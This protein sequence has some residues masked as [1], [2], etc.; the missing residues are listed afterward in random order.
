MFQLN[1]P[2][3]SYILINPEKKDNT[4][5]EN[6]WNCERLCSVLYSKD[7]TVVPIKE[8][9]KNKYS[10][11]FFGIFPLTNNDELRQETL[12]IL[13]FL[14][15]NE[16]IIKYN[17]S[18]SPIKITKFGEEIPLTFSVYENDENSR[19]Y[20]HNGVSFSFKETT[21]YFL[22]KHKDHLKNGMVVEYF[23]NNKWNTKEIVK[24]DEEFDK[25]YKLL[26]KYDKLRIPTKQ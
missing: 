6:N 5:L 15:I 10:R 9:Y 13:E 24:L 19:I 14:H 2:N 11:S 23:N 16:A 21:R 4:Q 25:M 26:I 17:G 20:I 3:I 12:Q 7:L 1:D 22:P 8:L 18:T